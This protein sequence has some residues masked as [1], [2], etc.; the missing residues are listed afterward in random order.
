[1]KRT[2]ETMRKEFLIMKRC[3][4]GALATLVAAG[5]LYAVPTPASAGT[6]AA[7]SMELAPGILYENRREEIGGIRNAVNILNLD[8]T[9]PGVRLELGVTEP[10]HKLSTPTRQ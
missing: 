2:E 7:S 1:M 3:L 9:D 6:L 5:S 10:I 4:H 8:L